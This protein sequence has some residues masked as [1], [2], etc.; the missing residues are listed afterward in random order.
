M[1]N[2]VR[3]NQINFNSYLAGLIEGDGFLMCPSEDNKVWK[4]RIGIAGHKKNNKFFEWLSRE[5]GYGEIKK[6]SSTNSLIFFIT[7]EKDIKDFCDRIKYFFRTGKVERINS[8]LSYY[9]LESVEINTSDILKDGWLAGISD[10]DSKFNVTIGDGKKA[11]KVQKINCQ[12]RLEWSTVTSNNKSDLALRVCSVLSKGLN[13]EVSIRTRKATLDQSKKS[14]YHT[15][16]VVVICHSEKQQTNLIEYLTKYP[17]LTAKRN[18]FENWKSIKLINDQKLNTNST[19]EKIKLVE[20]ALKLKN[21]MNNKNTL[22][23]SLRGVNWEH[24]KNI[25]IELT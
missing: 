25:K 10:A 17:L 7:N 16:S 20:A 15:H 4:P 23:H 22:Q 21:I 6:G 3:I 8:L 12:W 5:L 9:G 19:E 24:L 13:T 1:S 2:I 11:G 18:D 14:E